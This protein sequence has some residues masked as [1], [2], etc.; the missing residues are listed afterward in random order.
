MEDETSYGI[1]F[2]PQIGI[3]N[4]NSAIGWKKDDL[5]NRIRTYIKHD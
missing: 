4:T 5:L 2:E 3:P 1:T